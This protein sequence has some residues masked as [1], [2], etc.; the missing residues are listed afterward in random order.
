MSST[1][2]SSSFWIARKLL[3][4]LRAH[5]SHAHE[6]VVAYGQRSKVAAVACL[7]YAHGAL[8]HSHVA[9]SRLIEPPVT[10]LDR[11]VQDGVQLPN[12]NERS[13][14]FPIAD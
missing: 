3:S 10:D 14:H 8:L 9:R 12:A 5:V 1:A 2:L 4:P 6:C 11:E 13:P 7:V